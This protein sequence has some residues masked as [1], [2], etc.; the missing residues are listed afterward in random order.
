[1]AASTSACAATPPPSPPFTSSSSSS[2]SVT[3]PLP[4][5]LRPLPAV[6]PPDV[7][8]ANFSLSPAPSSPAASSSS[9][10]AS[11]SYLSYRSRSL[12]A[13]PPRGFEDPSRLQQRSVS[14]DRAHLALAAAVAA[15]AEAASTVLRP[16]QLQSMLAP[17]QSLPPPA[18]SLQPSSQPLRRDARLAHQA[19]AEP[20]LLPP[21]AGRCSRSHAPASSAVVCLVQPAAPAQLIDLKREGRAAVEAA[22]KEGR[23]LFGDEDDG[24]DSEDEE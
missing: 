5:P 1:M 6:R 2:S 9:A 16:L 15:A 23:Q 12:A 11:S 4:V 3:P 18:R 8:T 14:R 22:E 7:L 13:P 24:Q 21:A 17:H 20:A 19:P 10:A